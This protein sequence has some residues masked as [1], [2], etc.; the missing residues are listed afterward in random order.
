[1]LETPMPLWVP[2]QSRVKNSN[3]VAFQQ[4]LEAETNEQFSDYQ[5]LH[6]YTVTHNERFWAFY[7]RY[8]QLPFVGDYSAVIQGNGI[9]NTRWFEGLHC[10][11]AKACL[12]PSQT[13]SMQT[14]LIGVTETGNHV[15]ISYSELRHAVACCTNSLLKAGLGKGDRVAALIS[16]TSESVILLLA[17]A[18]QGIVFSSCSPDFGY[19]ASLARFKQIEPRLLFAS[20][21]YNYSGKNFSVINVIQKLSDNIN[22]I[23]KSIVIG[24]FVNDIANGLQ[25][26]ESWLA[27]K[28]TVCEADL[29][30]VDVEFD[31]P[32]YILYSSG[33]TGKPKAIVHRTG[34]VMLKHHSEHAL[35]SNISSGDNVLY[36]T[37]CGWMMWN[38][39][40]SGLMRGAC[41]ILYDGNPAYPNLKRLWNLI[42]E[43]QIDFFG[44]SARFLHGCRDANLS[45]KNFASLASLKTIA[46][47]GSPLS[48]NAFYWIYEQVKQDVHLASISGGTDIVG[49]FLMGNPTLP[50]YAGQLQV[51]TVGVDIA[52][53]NSNGEAVN[54]Q[55]GELVCRVAMPSMPLSFWK[56]DNDER[57]H[58]AY[59]AHYDN[60]WR[61]GDLLKITTE[62][63]YIVY[64]RSDATLNPGGVRI[65]TAEI[66]R[67]LE[68]IQE[69]I[70]AVAVG[71][72]INDDEV[73]WLF[74][75][76]KQN[77]TLNDALITRI[78]QC[79]RNKASPR[80]VPQQLFAV[81]Q[82]PRTRSGKTSEI[83]VRQYI[84]QQP[85]ANLKSLINPE[86]FD[87]INEAINKAIN[88]N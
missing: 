44:T 52:A 18:S 22:S 66:Y 29:N 21:G 70:E 5:S 27:D 17:C 26:W 61:H 12:Y 53:F 43:L 19:E 20:S 3:F 6:G 24:D 82:L 48:E 8:S 46:S 74:V 4:A 14:A 49:C 76:L 72:T 45:P 59:F 50:V 13:S 9:Q 31:H 80:H 78:K 28:T 15:S 79:I 25:C 40:V 34:G 67:P 36:F 51:A 87:S 33:T 68:E 73:I 38:W 2:S 69:I 55:T 1:M 84:N 65:G 54:N 39:L 56:D 41:L 88:A 58:D 42:D 32:L 86:S 11:Y 85:I 83:A 57:R 60:V 64:G 47:T 7:L 71:K 63:G 62:K 35:H 77:T 16:N 30:F 75:V 81:Q 10:N 37:T 23:E